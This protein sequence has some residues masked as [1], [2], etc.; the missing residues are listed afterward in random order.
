MLPWLTLESFR[1]AVHR[2][3]LGGAWLCPILPADALGATAGVPAPV[4]PSPG[5][6]APRVELDP[7]RVD[8]L[9]SDLIRRELPDW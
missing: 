8:E 1:S 5:V 6:P 9:W 3:L 4:P 2:M 7:G